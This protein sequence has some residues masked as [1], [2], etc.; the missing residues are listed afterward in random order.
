MKL[1]KAEAFGKYYLELLVLTL[2]IISLIGCFLVGMYFT[3]PKNPE[4][5]EP[6]KSYTSIEIQP[7][8][9][10]WSIASEHITEEYS[11]IQDYVMEIKA[12]NG[13]GDD[14]IHAGRFLIVPYYP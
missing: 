5:R 11:S 12:L 1:G 13:L 7:G 10:L 8:D 14:R 2:S 6:L 4:G 9:S 3:R